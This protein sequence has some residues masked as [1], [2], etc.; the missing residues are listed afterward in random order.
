MYAVWMVPKGL[1]PVFRKD[2]GRVRSSVCNE[3]Q[4]HLPDRENLTFQTGSMGA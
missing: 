3:H 2:V 4:Y 1:A